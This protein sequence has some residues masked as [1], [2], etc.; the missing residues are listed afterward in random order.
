MRITHFP[1]WADSLGFGFSVF[2]YSKYN[3]SCTPTRLL[4]LPVA[5]ARSVGAAGRLPDPRGVSIQ[6]RFGMAYALGERPS[7]AAA[8]AGTTT[9]PASSRPA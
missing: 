3:P 4:R 9:T 2:D 1:P 7:C 8:G 5:Q 6:P